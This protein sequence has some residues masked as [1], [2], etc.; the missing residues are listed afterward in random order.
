MKKREFLDAIKAYLA[1]TAS[2][3]QEF[4]LEDYYESFAFELNI[5]D[6]L[7]DAEVQRIRDRIFLEVLI[8]IQQSE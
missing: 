4:L 1:G 5:L 2:A 3:Y 6:L 8:H 7:P